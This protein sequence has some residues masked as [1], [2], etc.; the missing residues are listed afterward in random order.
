MNIFR[1][2][3][4]LA[5]AF[6]CS[7]CFVTH[8][9]I[10]VGFPFP[11]YDD[12]YSN[13]QVVG[14]SA[15]AVFF[16]RNY[17]SCYARRLDGTEVELPELD[18]D[19]TD[20]GEGRLLIRDHASVRIYRTDEYLENPYCEPL[21]TFT[22]AEENELNDRFDYRY[23]I[24]RAC[25]PARGVSV[26]LLVRDPV[27][28]PDD[29]AEKQSYTVDLARIDAD[30]KSAVLHSFL[31][32]RGDD[33]ELPLRVDYDG[34]YEWSDYDLAGEMTVYGSPLLAYYGDTIYARFLDEVVAVKE[35]KVYDTQFYDWNFDS[36]AKNKFPWSFS[37]YEV[38]NVI[39]QNAITGDEIH[40]GTLLGSDTM[41]FFKDATNIVLFPVTF[42]VACLIDF[43]AF[44]FYIY[45]IGSS[46]FGF[47]R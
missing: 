40:Y 26:A 35:G 47:V 12:E 21:M 43:F 29:E 22:V 15:E 23:A 24:A 42:P 25:A 41:R 8:E 34:R 17:T 5:S 46:G 20:L 9:V 2:I 33:G 3:F 19:F 31:V 38:D 1:A 16:T 45:A 13:V 44:P 28:G 18:Y 37:E 39:L 11:W 6:Q 27:E 10:E 7:G 4:I 14:A 36:Y 30:G 32:K